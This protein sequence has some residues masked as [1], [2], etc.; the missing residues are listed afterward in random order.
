MRIQQSLLVSHRSGTRRGKITDTSN[1]VNSRSRRESATSS[2]VIVPGLM[3]PG[4]DED[5]SRP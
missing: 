1:R 4:S 2:D 3:L 5:G